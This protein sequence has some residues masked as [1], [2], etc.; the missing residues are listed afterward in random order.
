[1]LR[2]ILRLLIILILTS[3]AYAE[4]ATSG[5]LLPNAGVGTTNLQ[6]SSG[7]VDGINGSTGWT[8]TGTTTFNNEIEANGTGTVSSNG[9]LVGITTE[10]QNGGQFTTTADSLDGGCLLYT[11][12]SP[13]DGL[14][15][16]MPSSA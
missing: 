6:N 15:S 7:N 1:M 14:L 8:T 4:Q 16:R 12:P 11:S 9:S 10:K 3:N 5:N 2:I 13:R